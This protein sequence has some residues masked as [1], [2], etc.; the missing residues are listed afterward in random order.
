VP[1]K[2]NAEASYPERGTFMTHATAQR[3]AGYA[4]PV[5]SLKVA[6]EIAFSKKSLAF[7]FV[8]ASAIILGVFLLFEVD[9][10]INGFFPIILI[11]MG[12]VDFLGGIFGANFLDSL[13]KRKS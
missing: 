2:F 9:S 13:K 8:G 5:I 3:Q 12:I 7:V 1:L 10:E 4:F 11:I 6:A